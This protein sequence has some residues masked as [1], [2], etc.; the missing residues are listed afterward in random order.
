MA[1]GADSFVS[2]AHVSDVSY[3]DDWEGDGL[4]SLVSQRLSQFP[5]HN[6]TNNEFAMTV[7]AWWERDGKKP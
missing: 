4:D 2:R 1:G 6:E 3:S 7:V 5:A